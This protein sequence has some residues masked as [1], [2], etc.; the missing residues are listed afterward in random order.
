VSELG[1]GQNGQ[2]CHDEL[3]GDPV[4]SYNGDHQ[5]TMD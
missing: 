1:A 4:T 5:A 2:T 3:H